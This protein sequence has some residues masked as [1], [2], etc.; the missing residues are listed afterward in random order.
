MS[1]KLQ[2]AQIDSETA[3]TDSSKGLDL[4]DYFTP[5]W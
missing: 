1:G 5:T 2:L 3:G 4:K